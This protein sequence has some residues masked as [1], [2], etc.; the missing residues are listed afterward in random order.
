MQL[1][2]LPEGGALFEEGGGAFGFV[3]GAAEASEDLCFNMD[4]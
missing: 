1:P 2:A 3:G 4:S